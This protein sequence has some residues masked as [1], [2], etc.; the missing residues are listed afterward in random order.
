MKKHWIFLGIVAGVLI[1][2]ILLLV[3][4]WALRHRHSAAPP[5]IGSTSPPKDRALAQGHVAEGFSLKEERRFPSALA[6]FQNAIQA[7]PN[8]S[9]SYHGLAQTQRE[10]G[11]PQAAVANH[12]RAIQL[13]PERHDLY[14][15]RGVTHMRLKNYDT[16]IADFE[17][18]LAKKSAFANA[19][20]GLA[21]SYQNKGEFQ[22]A[23]EHHDKAIA[24]KPDSA[25]FHRERGNT[26]RAMGDQQLAD[27]DFAKSRELE[28]N[29][30]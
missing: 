2:N 3:A 1:F 27:A 15:E 29:R 26:Y 28:Q 10:A 23:L 12:D 22:K 30:K 18:C 6:A 24:M 19:H 5:P 20:L 11:E 8:F 17:M 21:Q 14:W 4:I 25:W 16:A 7:D 13:D 9:D